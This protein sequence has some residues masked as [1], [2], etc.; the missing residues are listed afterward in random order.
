MIRQKTGRERRA[1]A[2]QR[3]QS[4]AGELVYALQPAGFR[5]EEP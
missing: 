3:V 2:A 4:V 5:T 1:R